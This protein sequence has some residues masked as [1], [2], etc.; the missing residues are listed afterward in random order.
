MTSFPVAFLVL[1][2]KAAAFSPMQAG[3]SYIA[4]NAGMQ[5]M[6]VIHT[7]LNVRILPSVILTLEHHALEFLHTVDFDFSTICSNVI[8][9]STLIL[10]KVA[11]KHEVG[12]FLAVT[13]E[14][15]IRRNGSRC[16]SQEAIFVSY[17][18][19]VHLWQKLHIVVAL[20]L[21]IKSAWF[22]QQ[23]ASQMTIYTRQPR[24]ASYFVICAQTLIS[25]S[26]FAC[27]PSQL[28]PGGHIVHPCIVDDLSIQHGSSILPSAENRG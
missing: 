19:I 15:R 7:A 20:H 23:L 12:E 27:R 21:T 25:S 8:S 14:L 16:S 17:F 22:Q 10:S 28:H 4:I 18:C 5:M 6:G 1:N 24:Q 9:M 26:I 3:L 13:P 2:C 11:R